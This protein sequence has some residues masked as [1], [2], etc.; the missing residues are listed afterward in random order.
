MGAEKGKGRFL[1]F[2]SGNGCWV[3]QSDHDGRRGAS[4]VVI[5]RYGV[6]SEGECQETL[7]SVVCCGCAVVVLCDLMFRVTCIRRLCPV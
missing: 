7:R 3:P 2:G 6:R 4:L 5:R 1:W